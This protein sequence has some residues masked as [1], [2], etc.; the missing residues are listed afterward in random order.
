MSLCTEWTGDCVHREESLVCHPTR[1][2][3]GA[4]LEL[5]PAPRRGISILR[6]VGK[7][8]WDLGVAGVAGRV[9]RTIRVVW[10]WQRGVAEYGWDVGP[11]IV[12]GQWSIGAGVAAVGLWE[13][14]CI[15]PSVSLQ[16]Y[17][18]ACG[19]CAAYFLVSPQ[20]E[21]RGTR[22]WL[23]A[24]GWCLRTWSQGG[25]ST[26]SASIQDMP[27]TTFHRHI[28]RG[29]SGAFPQSQPMA[30]PSSTLQSSPSWILAPST[31]CPTDQPPPCWPVAT[32]PRWPRACWGSSTP[33]PLHAGRC[34]HPT[35]HVPFSLSP[36]V[37]HPRQSWHRSSTV[38]PPYAEGL[39]TGSSTTA[40]ALGRAISQ[41]TAG[42]WPT[43]QAA[44]PAQGPATAPPVTPC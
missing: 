27:F 31:T 9:C 21:T 35:G 33:T 30:T 38:C 41:S 40:V 25:D 44:T 6:S 4:G 32:W 24:P 8:R 14:C 12:G 34:W 15:L 10:W 22:P 1:V 13:L 20:P 16:P 18:T 17:P 23:P 36:P 3:Q 28:L 19:I 5:G 11:C 2:L 39:A 26:F 7:G 43:G 42:T 29:T 37:W